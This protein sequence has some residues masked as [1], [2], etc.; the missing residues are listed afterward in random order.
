MRKMLWQ[1]AGFCGGEVLTY[2]VMSNHLH[3][4]VRVPVKEEVDLSV[5]NE[6]V[7]RRFGMLY[8]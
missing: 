7:L 4:V 3:I 8:G 5:S 2:A 1:M 6:E